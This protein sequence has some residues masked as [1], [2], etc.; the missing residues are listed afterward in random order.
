M[1]ITNNERIWQVVHEIPPGWVATYGQ[2]A[3]LAGLPGYARY[4]G[5][6][7]K[8]L[9]GSGKLPWHRVVNARGALSF[10]PES[11]QYRAQKLLLENEGI[12]FVNGKFSLGRYQW[13]P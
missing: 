2:V 13:K 4:V 8:Q 9:P 1:K 7:L 11:K 6:V 5:Y 12:V 10:A 3:Q